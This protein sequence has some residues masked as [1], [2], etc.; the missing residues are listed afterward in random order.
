ML[1]AVEARRRKVSPWRVKSR[2]EAGSDGK[3]PCK[4]VKGVAIYS[5]GNG[6]GGG[7]GIRRFEAKT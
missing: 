6:R 7:G 5:G 4:F 1:G 3:G 2:E